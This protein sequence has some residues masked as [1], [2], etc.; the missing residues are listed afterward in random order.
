VR[1]GLVAHAITLG[2]LLLFLGLIHVA[3]LGATPHSQG[4]A[5]VVIKEAQRGFVRV[6]ATPWARVA[7][8][9]KDVGVTPLAKPIALSEGTHTIRFDHDWY[10]S[11]ERTIEITPG[12]EDAAVSVMVDFEKQNVK[13]RPGKAKPAEPAP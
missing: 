7:I 3:P 10:V 11:V 1:A 4:Q 9:N 6:N 2:V 5:N 13:L 8:D 12:S